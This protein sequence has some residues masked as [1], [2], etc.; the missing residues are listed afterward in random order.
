MPDAPVGVF[1]RSTWMWEWEALKSATWW[2]M[3]GTQDQNVR[4][5][6]LEVELGVAAGLDDPHATR[7]SELAISS[8]AAVLTD[9]RRRGRDTFVSPSVGHTSFGLAFDGRDQ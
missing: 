2:V 8:T 9:E 6:V 5:T 7:P 1:T 4:F 3:P